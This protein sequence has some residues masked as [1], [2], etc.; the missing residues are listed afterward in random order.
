MRRFYTSILFSLLIGVIGSVLLGINSAHAASLLLP[1]IEGVPKDLGAAIAKVWDTV[2][3]VSGIA[4]LGLLLYGGVL[5]LTSMGQDQVL[6]KAKNTIRDAVIGIVLVVLA[7]PIG[8]YVLSFLGQA[9]VLS[10]SVPTASSTTPLNPASS[11]NQSVNS[12]APSNTT[13]PGNS[14]AP[15]S[16]N[17]TSSSSGPCF[18]ITSKQTVP[19]TSTTQPV[20]NADGS[21]S[22]STNLPT[23]QT[24]ISVIDNKKLTAVPNQQLN[25]YILDADGKTLEPLYLGYHSNAEGKLTLPL[26]SN[27]QI[28]VFD[29]LAKNELFRGTVVGSSMQIFTPTP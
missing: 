16:S 25:F 20:V 18:D 28:V 8:I 22:Y 15:G 11:S 27:K 23:T 13:T 3:G 10:K 1:T 17:S 5:Y 6:E 2:V 21:A 24:N 19:C 9:G 12:S 29:A 4:F 26:P 7:W 14:T